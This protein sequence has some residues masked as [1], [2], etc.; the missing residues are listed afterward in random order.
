VLR[1]GGPF[2]EDVWEE[3][4]LRSV[5]DTERNDAGTSIQLVSKCTRCLVS[6]IYLQ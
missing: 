4:N 6:Q 5:Y 2:A 3:I 1:G